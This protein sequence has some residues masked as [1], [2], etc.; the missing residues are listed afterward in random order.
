[1][2]YDTGEYNVLL[3]IPSNNFVLHNFTSHDTEYMWDYLPTVEQSIINDQQLIILFGAFQNLEEYDHWFVPI[4]ELCD[5]LPNKIIVFNGK[6]TSDEWRTVK[7]VFAYHQ[8][9]MFDHVS[10]IYID[11]LRINRGINLDFGLTDQKQHKFYWA[12]SKDWYTRRFILAGL[13]KHNLLNGNLINYKCLHTNIPSEWIDRRVSPRLGEII[14]SDCNEIQHLVPLPAIDDTVEF[15]QTNVQFYSDSYVGIVTDTFFDHGVFLSE[16]VFNAISY[17]Q[18][19]FYIGAYGSLKYLKSQGYHVFD[20]IIDIGYDSISDTGKRLIAARNSLLN[21]L[22]QP[23]ETI[24]KA[25]IKSMPSLKHNRML[26]QQQR[27]DVKITQH[28][29]ECLNEY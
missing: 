16:K 12:S 19:F 18:I 5:R 8:I 29:K 28:I 6:L 17:H 24:Q 9:G 23:L 26:L 20:D 7:P 4:N 14:E 13:I 15:M 27:P 22:N 25:Y 2:I 10:N 21:F 11:Q 3:E 1:M